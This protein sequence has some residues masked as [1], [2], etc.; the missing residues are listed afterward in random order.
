MIGEKIKIYVTREV[1][2]ILDKDAESFEFFKPNGSLNRNAFLTRLVIYYADRF[3]QKQ[4]ETIQY[5]IDTLKK[6][7]LKDDA[8]LVSLAAG[9][10]ERL[11]GV[12]QAVA[13]GRVDHIVSIKPTRQSLPII[14]YI[15]ERCLL[16]TSLSEH[17]RNM[18]SSYASL[19]QD[20]R[21]EII[22][23][24][25]FTV[26]SQAIKDKKQVF[27]TLR[28]T[29]VKTISVSPYCITRSKEELHLYLLATSGGGC[30]PLRL[31]RILSVTP[32]QE[33]AV[34]AEE[35]IAVF[36]KMLAYG[37]Q[38]IYRA[39]EGEAVVELTPAGVV[40]FKKMYVH[41]PIPNKIEGNRY[42][43][44]CSHSQLLQY[45]V[46]FGVDA[47]IVAPLRLRLDLLYFYKHA[48]SFYQSRKES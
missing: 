2:S 12:G 3:H 17:F 4:R 14:K 34:F 15:E 9:I 44:S 45:F 40:K 37:P 32:L 39:G 7:G 28:N 22:F 38:F 43:F 11:T 25:E 13:A 41:R 35:Q 30:S 8:R 24:P 18:L 1:S 31:S 16:G 46:R 29:N 33:P 19:P 5:L 23:S 27:L 48:V 36:E 42:Y 6:E 20:K 21:E 26:L 10:S 47:Y